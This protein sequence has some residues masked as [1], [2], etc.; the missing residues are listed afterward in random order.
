[1][2][3]PSSLT[4]SSSFSSSSLVT[5][6]LVEVEEGILAELGGLQI[7]VTN[8]NDQPPE[9]LES[10]IN[11]IDRMIKDVCHR[12]RRDGVKSAKIRE[13]M[14][15]LVRSKNRLAFRV[16]YA[17]SMDKLRPYSISSATIGAFGHDHAMRLAHEKARELRQDNVVVAFAEDLGMS[18]LK[19]LFTALRNG[20]E[21]VASTVGHRPSF[22][23]RLPG[24]GIEF[25]ATAREFLAKE[26]GIVDDG[27]RH[28]AALLSV[29]I[30]LSN[31][32]YAESAECFFRTN[33]KTLASTAME[34]EISKSIVQHYFPGDAGSQEAIQNRIL[35]AWLRIKEAI[36]F[37]GRYYL[38]GIP[39][40]IVM[41]PRR[42]FLYRSH[43][44]GT[45]CKASMD[46][47]EPASWVK[48]DET[49]NVK[50]CDC[51]T[52]PQGRLLVRGLELCDRVSVYAYDSMS[53][54]NR[55]VYEVGLQALAQSLI[56]FIPIA[57]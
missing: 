18:F 43:P 13:A 7:C 56:E 9:G 1:M 50:A 14:E 44:F 20:T 40:D 32:H 33:F 54:E 4:P 39:L 47:E 35:T 41:D 19:D 8:M 22:S 12:V 51:G 16:H 27:S 30:D 21:A 57:V 2:S 23:F 15:G 55:K 28:R 26:G 37:G 48:T 24:I 42:S 11:W 31:K 34:K 3:A 49:G 38:I 53:H 45:P 10:G 36:R 52:N 17:V 46:S 29:D 5:S 25:P 6:P